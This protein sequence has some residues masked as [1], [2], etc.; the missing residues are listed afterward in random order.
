MAGYNNPR[1]VDIENEVL[2]SRLASIKAA[3]VELADAVEKY[4]TPK[5]GDPYCGRGE[6]LRK[7]EILKN[8][9]K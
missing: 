3:A 5:K 2:R 9:L 1:I 4:V 8:L 7:K 6:V